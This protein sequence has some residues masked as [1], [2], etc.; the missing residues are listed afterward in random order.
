MQPVAEMSPVNLMSGPVFERFSIGEALHN[1]FL[2]I[3]RGEWIESSNTPEFWRQEYPSD[4]QAYQQ[5]MRE[6]LANLKESSA[7]QE[8]RQASESDGEISDQLCDRVELA[9]QRAEESAIKALTNVLKPA[10]LRRLHQASTSEIDYGFRDLLAERLTAD[11]EVPLRRQKKAL[12]FL[13]NPKIRNVRYMDSREI[14]SGLRRSLGRGS[15]DQLKREV[16]AIHQ[17]QGASEVQ[18]VA[19]T[20]DLADI[21]SQLANQ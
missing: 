5:Y 17:N 1:Q 11:H 15:F 9:L 13:I 12:S 4:H 14:L 8:L 3:E 19:G 2:E 10:Q 7:I 16:G 18:V 21:E 20:D 6:V